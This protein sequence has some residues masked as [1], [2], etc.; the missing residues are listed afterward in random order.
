MS[1]AQRDYSE[2]A[3]GKCKENTAQHDFGTSGFL[4]DHTNYHKETQSTKMRENC[5]LW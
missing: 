2:K 1:S 5:L 4:F 3:E